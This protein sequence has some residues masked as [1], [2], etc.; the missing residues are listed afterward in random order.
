MA[1]KGG[2]KEFFAKRGGPST[3][4]REKGALAKRS[5]KLTWN[6]KPNKD[7]QPINLRLPPEKR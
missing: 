5:R 6:G 2:N 1:N 4:A 3:Q 7:Y